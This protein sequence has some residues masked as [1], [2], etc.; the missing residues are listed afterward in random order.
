ML[1]PGISRFAFREPGNLKPI[2]IVGKYEYNS[3]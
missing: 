2:D 3:Q 1:L